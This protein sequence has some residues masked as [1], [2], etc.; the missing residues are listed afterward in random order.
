MS[1]HLIRECSETSETIVEQV[2]SEKRYYIKGITLQSEICNKNRRVY[3]KTVLMDSIDKYRKDKIETGQ[4]L[5][6]LHHPDSDKKVAQIDYDRAS[7]KFVEV[8]ESGNNWIAKALVT[9]TPAGNTVRSLLEDGVT[10]GISSRALGS[11]VESNGARIVNKLHIITLG[12]LVSD[13]SAPDAFVQG[14]LENK[15]WI[16][17]N[18][19]LVSKDFEPILDGWKASIKSA[20]KNKIDSI[21]TGIFSDY[22]KRLAGK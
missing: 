12:D 16:W 10:F 14:V 9:K 21:I 1:L 15:E 5:G 6:E 11:T 13:P 4:A 19:Q 22:F 20:D 3:P 18:G 8:Y 7:H 17:E 2:D